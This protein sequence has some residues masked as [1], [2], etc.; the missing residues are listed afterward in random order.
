MR[1]KREHYKV[2]QQVKQWES[3]GIYHSYTYKMYKSKEVDGGCHIVMSGAKCTDSRLL[4]TLIKFS[5]Q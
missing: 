5:F 4:S 1:E 3:S 2:A